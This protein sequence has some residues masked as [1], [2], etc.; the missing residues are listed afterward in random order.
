MAQLV[1]YVDVIHNEKI[2]TYE[3]FLYYQT[4]VEHIFFFE[5]TSLD[6]FLSLYNT[7]QRWINNGLFYCSNG[8]IT[9][10]IIL[11]THIIFGQ[12]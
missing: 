8:Y 10:D 1:R 6:S 11:N 2:I 4:A 5:L 12:S 9:Y 3:F 7:H